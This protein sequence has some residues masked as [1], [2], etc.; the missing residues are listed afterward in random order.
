MDFSANKALKFSLTLFVLL[1]A[2]ACAVK[3]V[4]LNRSAFIESKV[5]QINV[6]SLPAAVSIE[7]SASGSLGGAAA[8]GL[9]GALVGAAIDGGINGTRRSDLAPI[10]ESLKDFDVNAKF[11]E[12]LDENVTG[13]AFSDRIAFVSNYTKQQAKM[14]QVPTLT[15]TTTMAPNFAALR[16]SLANR[17]HQIDPDGKPYDKVY[18]SALSVDDTQIDV[19]KEANIKFWMENPRTLISKIEEGL[20]YV[21]QQFVDDLNAEGAYQ[22]L[23]ESTKQVGQVIS[24]HDLVTGDEQGSAAADELD[25]TG[26]D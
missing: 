26:A 21:V 24:E 20:R 14:K 2:S 16:V 19:S 22:Q 25:L 10:A 17:I 15:P 13:T 6:T 3:Q 23:E 18:Y 9:L 8:A 7:P 12:I 11:L 5:T 1:A 4:P